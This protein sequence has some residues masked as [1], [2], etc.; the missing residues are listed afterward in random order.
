MKHNYFVG[1]TVIEI[2]LLADL[3]VFW[4]ANVGVFMGLRKKKSNTIQL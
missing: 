2:M 4:N 1:F 3:P